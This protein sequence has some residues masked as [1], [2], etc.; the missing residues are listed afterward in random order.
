MLNTVVKVFKNQR[1]LLVYCNFNKSA[2]GLA[3]YLKQNGKNAFCFHGK[4]T[5]V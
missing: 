3:T 5:E 2:E 1:P 4:M